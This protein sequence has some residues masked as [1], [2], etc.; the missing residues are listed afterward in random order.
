MSIV[1]NCDAGNG[2]ARPLSRRSRTDPIF[3]QCG[4]VCEGRESRV[5]GEFENVALSG[6]ANSNDKMPATFDGMYQIANLLKA[7]KAP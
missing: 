3:R 1:A 2:R 4:S 6:I 7:V 5:A